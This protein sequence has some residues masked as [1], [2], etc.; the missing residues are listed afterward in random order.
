MGTEPHTVVGDLID[1]IGT[2]AAAADFGPHH[3]HDILQDVLRR[4]DDWLDPRYQDLAGEPVGKLYPL[5]RA[6]DRRWSMLVA[7]FAPGART[8]VHDHGSWAVTGT[9]RGREQETWFQRTDDGSVPGR[10]QLVA[11][12][13]RVNEPGT[14]CA[15]PDGM[16]HTVEALDG[17][18]AVSLH[19][20][21]TDI[22]TQPRRTYDLDAGTEAP[23]TPAFA[24]EV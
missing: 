15:V 10:A 1:R 7:V 3:V 22:V 16:I 20:Y 14:V 19:V 24:V 23:F 5:Y 17:R 18:Q 8:P 12:L 11:E 13:T 21:G 6:P 4:D 2:A 9:Y